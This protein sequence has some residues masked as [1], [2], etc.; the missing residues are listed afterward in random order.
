M[1]ANMGKFS[2]GALRMVAHMAKGLKVLLR[3]VATWEGD[4]K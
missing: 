2:I 4:Q 3:M 1:V